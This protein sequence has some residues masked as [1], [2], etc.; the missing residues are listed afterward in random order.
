MKK[1]IFATLAFGAAVAFASQAG[2]A[3]KLKA[4]LDG[5]S[6]VPAITTGGT[7]S[8]ELTFD[9]A[10]KKLTWTVTYSGL[11][12]P[13]TA[14]HFHGPAEAGKNAGVA[15]A[16][17]NAAASPVKGEA[18]LTDA[19]ASDLMAGK[20]YINIHTAANPGGEIRG[21]VMK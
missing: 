1:A 19:Q 12:G 18:T 10:S 11:S 15:V 6:E 3:D 13:A 16:I 9:P 8:A 17:P 5:K 7:G 2:A 21:Q 4:T 20:Y 14:A